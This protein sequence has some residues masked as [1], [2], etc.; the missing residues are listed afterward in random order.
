MPLYSIAVLSYGPGWIPPPE[1]NNNQL[2]VDA[3]NTANKQSW[4]AIFKDSAEST[5]NEVP[6]SLLKN[7]VMN[8]APLVNDSAINQSRDTIRNFAANV[9]P[10]RC[11]HRLNKFEKE[12]LQWLKNAVRSRKIAI[13]QADKGGCILIVDPELI[14]SCTVEKLNVVSRYTPLGLANTLPEIRSLLITLWKYALTAGF[15]TGEQ[16]KKTV[17]LYYKPAPNKSN[18]FS[19]S[20]SDKF[21]PGICYP[22]P[23]FKIHKCSSSQL[24]DPNV[25]PPIRLN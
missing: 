21:K 6:F 10:E 8:P 14:L 7:D 17:G 4:A 25:Q 18:P 13:T 3:L 2:K 1:P 20:T 5:I 11:K 23:V 15:V 9:S 16:S 12:G 19:L 22:Y 24:E